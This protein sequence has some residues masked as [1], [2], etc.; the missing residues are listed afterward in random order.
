MPTYL[1]SRTDD[2]AA[3]VLSRLSQYRRQYAGFTSA[4]RKTIYVNFFLPVYGEQW[5][6]E[7]VLVCDGGIGFWGIEFD[8]TSN[9]F[10]HI[11]YNG[12]G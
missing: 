10:S 2:E 8:T 5:R 11:A 1:R 6:T 9:K 12:V 3:R 7:V 4:G